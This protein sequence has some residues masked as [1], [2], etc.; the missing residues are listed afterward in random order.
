MILELSVPSP[1]LTHFPTF[2]LTY[3]VST[4]IVSW[5]LTTD[6]RQTTFQLK[7]KK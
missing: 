6:K 5:Q 4:S 2:E 3:R 7:T 1:T